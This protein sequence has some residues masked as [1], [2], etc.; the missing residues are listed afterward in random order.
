MI[1]HLVDAGIC[2]A[3]VAVSAFDRRTEDAI[4]RFVSS[5]AAD[6]GVQL[7]NA[8]EQA[9][10][11]ASTSWQA[12]FEENGIPSRNQHGPRQGRPQ[13]P[14]SGIVPQDEDE[15][16]EHPD[17]HAP[18]NGL[19]LQ[20]LILSFTDERH[21]LEL[22]KACEDAQDISGSRRLADLAHPECDHNWLWNLSKHK[23]PV[24]EPP[25]F[26]E[27]LRLRLGAAGPSEPCPCQ[28]CGSTLLDSA[29]SHALCCNLAEATRGHHRVAKQVYEPARQCDP[30]AE[31][32]APGL[33]PGTRL[34]PADVL[35]GALGH[36]LTALDI[37]IASPDASHAGDDCTATMYANKLAT[38]APYSDVLDR[39][40]I[41]YQPLI[42]SAYG[43][44]HPRTTAV[45]RTLATRLA[46]RRGCSDAEWRFRRLRA[47]I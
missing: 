6:K 16:L 40:N 39:Q 33:I 19:K 14:G 20:R 21:R 18:T 32:E 45:L 22:L 29:G 26:V 31:L 46:R 28:L 7:V 5:L 35:T 34:R 15:D 41:T 9:A 2:E 3:G 38:Y 4:T 30:S 44:P 10:E 23:G 8:L 24:M 43:R 17:A 1:G 25:Q 36:G 13:H 47:A 37:G 42:W 27:A 11:D 12:L